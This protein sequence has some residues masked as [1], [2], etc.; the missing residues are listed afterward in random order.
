MRDFGS[1]F[2]LVAAGSALVAVSRLLKMAATIV[3]FQV[4]VRFAVD[5]AQAAVQMRNWA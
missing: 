3:L 1:R 2:A 4:F 5:F